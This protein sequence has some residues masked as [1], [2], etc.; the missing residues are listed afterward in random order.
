MV[1]YDRQIFSVVAVILA[2]IF[3]VAGNETRFI[4]DFRNTGH[5]PNVDFHVEFEPLLGVLTCRVTSCRQIKKGDE[6]LT[7][8]G[9]EYWS[10]IHANQPL[11][12]QP[13]QN[14]RKPAIKRQPQ[15]QS[16]QQRP[17][18]TQKRTQP[19]RKSMHDY[20]MDKEASQE[21]DTDFFND[22]AGS[23]EQQE[24]EY[25]ADAVEDSDSE[26]EQNDVLPANM[27]DSEE[28]NSDREIQRH[29]KKRVIIHVARKRN[30]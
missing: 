24:Y 16:P 6:I 27:S 13:Q 30:I 1:C 4:N 3:V 14:T 2:I 20:K 22:E 7:D 23:D 25:E 12:Q 21:S 9:D 26:H 15:L 8:Y 5:Q 29:E 19:A 28:S 18:T 10:A 11:Y 17:Q